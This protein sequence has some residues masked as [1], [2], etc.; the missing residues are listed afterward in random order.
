MGTSYTSDLTERQFEPLR[1][2]LEKITKRTR[3]RKVDLRDIFNAII[4]LLRNATKWRD[5]PKDYPPWKLVYYYFHIWKTTLDTETHEPMLEV[6]L[7][8]IG[9]S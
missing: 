5:I 9:R 6:I 4:Y 8:K 1:P 3:P 2:I 7:K